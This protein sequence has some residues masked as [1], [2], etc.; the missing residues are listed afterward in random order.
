MKGGEF[1]AFHSMV[2]NNSIILSPSQ[3]VLLEQVMNIMC[4]NDILTKSIQQLTE[5]RVFK[6]GDTVYASKHYSDKMLSDAN[7]DLCGVVFNNGN[8]LKSDI[9]LGYAVCE[10]KDD[11]SGASNEAAPEEVLVNP[12]E[13][14]ALEEE[15]MDDGRGKKEDVK[16]EEAEEKKKTDEEKKEEFVDNSKIIKAMR[17]ISV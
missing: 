4:F 6:F 14:E 5:K 2:K 1:V 12:Q 3:F 16:K 10:W 13:A 8:K 7:L 15:E 11:G 17:M 9:K